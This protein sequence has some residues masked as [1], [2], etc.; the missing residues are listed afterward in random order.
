[1]DSLNMGFLYLVGFFSEQFLGGS[2]RD[3]NP[4]HVAAIFQLRLRK[5]VSCNFK[6]QL[7]HQQGTAVAIPSSN[8][9]GLN[10]SS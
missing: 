9:Q 3:V 7:P 4:F 5:I 1:M 2:L 6:L 8:T 10:H